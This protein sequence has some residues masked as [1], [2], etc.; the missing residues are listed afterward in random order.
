MSSKGAFTNSI[1]LT[2]FGQRFAGSDVQH[3]ENF[4]IREG[5][6]LCY[7]VGFGE[8]DGGFDPRAIPH[9]DLTKLWARDH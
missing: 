9:E 6:G 8:R 4:I 7:H 1:L 3:P 5:L 2:S